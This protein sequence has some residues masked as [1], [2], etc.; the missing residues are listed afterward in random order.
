MPRILLCF[1]G[2][3]NAIRATQYVTQLV[4]SL[5][6]PEICVVNVQPEPGVYGENALLLWGSI[7][8]AEA[9][10]RAAGQKLLEPA[11]QL[12][13]RAMSHSSYS[14]YVRLGSPAETINDCAAELACDL[15]VLGSRG[16]G[17]LAGILV[18]SV[19]SKILH[20]ASVPVMVVR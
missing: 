18:G 16:L 15:I 7:E 8:E 14:T 20:L 6:D 19:T 11:E 10:I 2:S 1:D 9:A 5:N 13:D 3:E 4:Q 12:L 17:A